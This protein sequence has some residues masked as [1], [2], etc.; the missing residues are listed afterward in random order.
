[1][2]TSRRVPLANVPNA[3]NSP[4]RA[5]PALNTKRHRSNAADQRESHYGQPP[6]AKKQIIEGEGLEG[7]GT[8]HG[9]R[10]VAEQKS[11]H[12]NNENAPQSVG[13]RKTL[14]M[15]KEIIASQQKSGE[16]SQKSSLENLDTI[17]QWQKYYR[18]VFPSFVFYFESIPDEIRQKASRQTA[19]FGAKEEQF[20][21]KDVTHVV[22]TRTI[23]PESH[24]TSPDGEGKTSSSSENARSKPSQPKTINPSLLDRLDQPSDIKSHL[25]QPKSLSKPE[26]QS[27]RLFKTTLQS[28]Q[29]SDTKKLQGN[30]NG[31]LHK[32]REMG[33]KIW[34]LEKFHRIMMT[35]FESDM[36]E[37]PANARVPRNSAL[38][39]DTSKSTKAADLS[40]LL[41]NEKLNG[42]ADLDRATAT[43]DM[44]QFTG[45]YIYVH[46]M[47]EQTRPVMARDYKKPANREDGKWPQFRLT[48]PGRCPFVEDTAHLKKLQMQDKKLQD[49]K[50][51]EQRAALAKSK[52]EVPL[53]R[54][55]AATA[56]EAA[57][58]QPAAETQEKRALTEIDSNVSS[59]PSTATTTSKPLEPPKLIPAKRTN[60]EVAPPILFG[61]AQA[62]LRSLPRFAGGE[63]VASGV[64]PSNVTSA[65][66][67]QMISST[68]AAPGAMTNS[69]REVH[70]LQRKVLE[71][72]SGPSANSMPSSYMNDVRAAINADMPATRAAARKAKETITRVHEDDADEE[73]ERRQTKQGGKKKKDQAAEKDLKPGYCENC[74]EKFED[75]DQ[76]VVSRKHRKFALTLDN[77]KELDALLEK[78]VRPRKAVV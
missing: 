63:P 12:Q 16:K 24:L 18:R 43:S 57:R 59:R 36:S 34:S 45:C 42:P 1:M 62:S 15:A 48:G 76:H 47:D 52:G 10:K 75:F 22:T 17:R 74:R 14:L 51:Q 40:R 21:S 31:I 23:P 55:R 53:H 50:F 9:F 13:A 49:I 3:T 68:A 20:F 32:A 64:Q 35:M 67:S 73:N 78:L 33:M 54:T 41:K 39:A 38:T 4:R 56:I 70:K 72:N 71:R 69:S 6:P 58:A 44:V 77:W 28:I 61:S 25:H 29:D 46:D 5:V 66:R 11:H 2:M 65:I 7:R 8:A 30:T 19:S 27:N 60:S 37:Q 26:G